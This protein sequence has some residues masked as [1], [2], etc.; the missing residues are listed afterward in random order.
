MK[1]IIA[2]SRE[3]CKR[4]HL[5]AALRQAPWEITVVVCGMCRG[6]DMLGYRW[7]NRVGVPVEEFPADWDKHDDAAGGI[8]NRQMADKAEALIALWD[9]E[10]SG[11]AD[12]IKVAKARRL[13]VFVYYINKT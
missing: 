13:E 3:G 1:T 2:G 6:A 5:A 7:G 9:G 4:R 8:R 12:M 10:S 11:T